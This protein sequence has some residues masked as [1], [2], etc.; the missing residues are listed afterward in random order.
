MKK[1]LLVLQLFTAFS[2][3]EASASIGVSSIF[4]EPGNGTSKN[5]ALL[6]YCGSGLFLGSSAAVQ[7]KHTITSSAESKTEADSFFAV[8]PESSL[9][10]SLTD[11]AFGI[12]AGNISDE[13][14]MRE[15]TVD[16]VKL[17]IRRA[18]P[19]AA[20]SFSIKRSG[21]SAGISIIGGAV[22]SEITSEY[23]GTELSEKRIELFCEPVFG[24]YTE[25]SGSPFDL[26]FKFKAVRF[27][28]EWAK[29][30]IEGSGNW[31]E[32]R[33]IK[34]AAELDPVITAGSEYHGSGRFDYHGEVELSIPHERIRSTGSMD[35]KLTDRTESRPMTARIIIGTA[36]RLATDTR[37]FLSGGI[38]TTFNKRIENYE[39]QNCNRKFNSFFALIS[40]NTSI[41]D[42]SSFSAGIEGAYI[43]SDEAYPEFVLEEKAFQAKLNLGLNVKF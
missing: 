25:I 11:F 32:T 9:S 35:E 40:Y 21:A 2:I 7:P 12:S 3:C 13:S 26:G 23:D 10:V 41:K 15:I 37:I 34:F 27:F 17:K 39:F 22:L 19:S 20:L 5:P 30:E 33:T 43:L 6:S 16:S 18:V 14:Y 31:K 24:Y 29:Y 1:Y 38:K 36:Y 8:S 4:P 42:G 28:R